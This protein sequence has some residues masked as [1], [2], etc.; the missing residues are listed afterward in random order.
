MLSLGV[1]VS[2]FSD[3]LHLSENKDDGSIRWWMPHDRSW[4]LI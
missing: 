2:E 1:I 3:E 4:I